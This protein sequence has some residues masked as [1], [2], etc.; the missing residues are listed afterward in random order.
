MKLNTRLGYL[1]VTFA[2]L[3]EDE[4]FW[5]GCKGCVNYDVLERPDR[6][7]CICTGMLFNPHDPLCLEMA[8]RE[9]SKDTKVK[10]IVEKAIKDR[11]LD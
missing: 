10:D 5:K 7:Y 4:T 2:D 11:D 8:E 1:P 6:R 3:T 9:M